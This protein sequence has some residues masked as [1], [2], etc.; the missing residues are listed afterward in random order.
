MRNLVKV[1]ES[2][3]QK[4]NIAF[5]DFYHFYDSHINYGR[6]KIMSLMKFQITINICKF[7]LTYQDYKIPKLVTGQ[8]TF[9]FFGD[10]D[11]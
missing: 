3:Y 6:L 8:K 4:I 10:Y 11:L 5:P 1:I 9:Q 7:I 2:N